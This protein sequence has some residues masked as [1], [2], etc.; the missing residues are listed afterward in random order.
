MRA[1]NDMLLWTAS[2]GVRCVIAAYDEARYQL[3]ILRPHGT[4]KAGL[5]DTYEC[6]LEASR[7]WRNELLAS[8]TDRHIGVMKCRL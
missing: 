4:F 2:D 1:T 8:S 7:N 6:A 3:R 5:F